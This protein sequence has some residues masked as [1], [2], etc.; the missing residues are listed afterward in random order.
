MAQTRTLKLDAFYDRG[1]PEPSALELLYAARPDWKTTPGRVRI[2]RLLGGVP[3][4]ILKITKDVP[5]KSKSENDQAAVVL[6]TNGDDPN[7]LLGLDREAEAR[8]HEL[9]AEHG[10]A[11]PLLARFG[12]GLLYAYI[13][14]RPCKPHDLCCEEVW[15]SVAVKLGEFHAKLTRAN[16]RIGG[17]GGPG[18]KMDMG[19]PAPNIWSTM[20]RW[21]NVLPTRTAEEKSLRLELQTELSWSLER[22]G[23]SK[24][25]PDER[26]YVFGHCDLLSGNILIASAADSKEAEPGEAAAAASRITPDRIRIIDYE[27]AMYCPAAFDIANHF[28][29]WGGFA[30]DYTTLPGRTVR[31]EFI[32]R[33]LSSYG[34]HAG[35]ITADLE[36]AVSELA[37]AVDRFR[38]LPGLLWAVHAFVSVLESKV[39]FDWIPYASKRLAEYRAWKAHEDGVQLESGGE[40]SLRERMWARE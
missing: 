36:L 4:T 30:C 29:E 26:A 38:G 27:C 32:G 10:L 1:N 18:V 12:N 39:D 31:R 37:A 11:S 33:Y 5:G 17:G 20:Q 23:R 13:P 3:N 8:T 7:E 35:I 9:L 19:G 2:E 16:D 21:I 34:E 6:R 15:A 25:S 14:G 22:L 28:S 40:V 24:S